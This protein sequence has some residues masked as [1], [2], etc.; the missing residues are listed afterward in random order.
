MFNIL[1]EKIAMKALHEILKI[2][3]DTLTIRYCQVK[4]SAK[5]LPQFRADI[6]VILYVAHDMLLSLIPDVKSLFHPNPAHVASR[7]FTKLLALEYI[8]A[9]ET[10]LLYN[11]LQLEIL[12]QLYYPTL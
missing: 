1:P 8:L 11:I 5:R 6:S 9:M 2:S 12:P 7:L 10:L 3:L 4:P